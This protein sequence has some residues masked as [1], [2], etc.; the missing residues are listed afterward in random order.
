M[1]TQPIQ[2]DYGRNPPRWRRRKV[3]IKATILLAVAL[4]ALVTWR[5]A[6][7]WYYQWAYR[8]E[9][10]RWYAQAA[11]WVEPPTKLKYTENP[12]DF[13]GKSPRFYSVR[14][15]PKIAFM[16]FGGS[17]VEHLPLFDTTGR[18]IL[19]ASP[20][21][22]ML[23]M[24]ERTTPAGLTRLIAVRKPFFE[25]NKLRFPFDTIGLLNKDYRCLRGGTVT[26]DMT[27]ICG[28]GEIRIFA[29]QPDPADKSRFAISF[30]ARGRRGYFDG[31]FTAGRSVSKDPASVKIEQEMNSVV[32]L[33]VRMEPATRP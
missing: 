2:L 21:E 7:Q 30:E 13:A 23:L 27:G 8:R 5:H 31:V 32:E 29:G 20:D 28:P 1:M 14:S 6:R 26:L 4:S 12:S 3:W 15:S 11:N 19:A 17:P 33:T 24:H 18:P 16:S 22:A 10:A 9:A 25:G